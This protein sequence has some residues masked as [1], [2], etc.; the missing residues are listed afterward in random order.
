[1]SRG[2]TAARDIL[3]MKETAV[4]FILRFIKLVNW[5]TGVV[6]HGYNVDPAAS[7]EKKWTHYDDSTGILSTES[8]SV[9]DG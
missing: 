9:T 7:D 8:D 3:G 5:G 6:V 1:M 2:I 4:P